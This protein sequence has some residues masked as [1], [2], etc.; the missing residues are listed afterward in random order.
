M[1]SS[2]ESFDLTPEQPFRAPW[3]AQAF[4]LTVALHK[5]GRFTWPD[6]TA[7]LAAEIAL[8]ERS[9]E[10]GP[11]RSFYRCW[12]SALEKL[13][14]AHALAGDAELR[15]RRIECSANAAAH[16]HAARREPVFP[17][18]AGAGQMEAGAKA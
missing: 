2:P 3:E 14:V 7:A 5:A 4:A 17:A 16:A 18:L 1:S 13:V 8:A 12:L 10:P 11:D 15:V 9:G 6:W